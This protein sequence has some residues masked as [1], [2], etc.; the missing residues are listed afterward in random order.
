LVDLDRTKALIQEIVAAE[1]L[2]LVEVEFKGG[3]ISK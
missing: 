2:E 3:L 1:G